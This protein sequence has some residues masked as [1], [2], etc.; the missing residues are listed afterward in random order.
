[1]STI[2]RD[3]TR[4]QVPQRLMA[5][6][7][8]GISLPIRSQGSWTPLARFADLNNKRYQ[9]AP[10]MDRMQAAEVCSLMSKPC[11]E[12]RPAL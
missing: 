10:A 6:L 1:M 9:Q 3:H 12:C 2:S 5:L 11:S 7:T 8:T 4:R